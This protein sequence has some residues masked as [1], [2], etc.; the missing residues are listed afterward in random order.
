MRRLSHS[1][2]VASLGA[3]VVTS[4]AVTVGPESNGTVQ[5][6]DARALPTTTKTYFASGASDPR[7]YW[8]TERMA[9]ATP[10]LNTRERKNPRVTVSD[11]VGNNPR[12]IAGVGVPDEKSGRVVSPAAEQPALTYP[13]P[14][15]RRYIEKQLRK[16]G[17]Y[18][19]VG[20]VFFRRG[21]SKYVCSGAS[22]V[23][24]PRQVVFTAGHCLNDGQGEW[25][26]DVIFVPGRKGGKNKNPYGRFAAKE[27]WVPQGWRDEALDAFDMGTFNVG[28]NKKGKKLQ[29]AVGAL[30]FAYNKSRVQH[31]DVFG[32]PAQAP[33]KGN[34]LV[35]CSA[36]WAL[37]DKEN[38]NDSIGIGCD[39]NGGSSGGPWILGLRRGNL[40]NGI[41]TYGYASQPA[42]QYGPY[43]GANA[44]WIR[45]AA[46]KSNALAT[47]C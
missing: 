44:N 31:W 8:T 37:D 46:A 43:F 30:G 22:V 36:Q 23:S 47:S 19:T 14:F 17:P 15:G 9:A 45:C 29:K 38:G 32:Y 40:L 24:K 18:R 4:V 25:S 21:G 39:M 41:V 33:F 11:E 10:I 35:T 1:I 28:K 34:N 5:G 2:L 20:R 12:S 26:T 7:D 27:L 16:V 42:A 3:L 13:F 6:A